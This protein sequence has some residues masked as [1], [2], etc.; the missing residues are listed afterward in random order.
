VQMSG[1]LP[2]VYLVRH[3]ETAWTISGQHT[4]RT[5]IPLTD[6]GERDAQKLG[7]RLKGLNFAQVLS[8]PLQRA[9]R[10][11]ELAGFRKCTDIDA[12]LAEWDYGT[13]EGRRTADIRAERPGWRLLEDGCPGGEKLEALSARA[14][15]VIGH[16]RVLGGDVLVFAH[17]DILRILTARWLRL[18]AV[19][20]R[21]F[22]LATK[23]MRKAF[24]EK[25]ICAA[26]RMRRKPSSTLCLR[27]EV[28]GAFSKEKP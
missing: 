6:Q 24:A 11:A 23:S 8:S 18:N 21:N 20:A 16:I 28:A 27:D 22:Y 9:R 12:D 2:Q 3:G 13:Y 1:A 10:T 25:I 5:D 15:R 19:E 7:A 4:G 26:S 14:E 17:R